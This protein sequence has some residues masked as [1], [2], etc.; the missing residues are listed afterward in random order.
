[1][2]HQPCG[3]IILKPKCQTSKLQMTVVSGSVSKTTI[4]SFISQL[5]AFTRLG[6]RMLRSLIKLSKVSL[7]LQDFP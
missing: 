7:V 6:I 5:F 4:N 2:T 3:M 1:M